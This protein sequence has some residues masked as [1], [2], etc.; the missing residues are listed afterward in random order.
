LNSAISALEQ[1]LTAL[2][3]LSQDQVEMVE[4]PAKRAR[5]LAVNIVKLT[6]QKSEEDDGDD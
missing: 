1:A 6:V 3:E 4:K 2:A 5:K